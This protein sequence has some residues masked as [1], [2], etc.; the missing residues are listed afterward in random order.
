MTALFVCAPI[1]RPF[2]FFYRSPNPFPAPAPGPRGRVFFYALTPKLRSFLCAPQEK[3][4]LLSLN[5]FIVA[6]VSDTELG[7]SFDDMWVV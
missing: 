1:V 7:E 6:K 4:M 5:R 2:F 3:E